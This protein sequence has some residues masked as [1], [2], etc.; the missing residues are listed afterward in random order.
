MAV[1]HILY[2]HTGS[3]ASLFHNVP[4]S[5]YGQLEED[6]HKIH[7]CDY[8]QEDFRNWFL[9]MVKEI[10]SHIQATNKEQDMRALQALQHWLTHNCFEKACSYRMEEGEQLLH[11]LSFS[12]HAWDHAQELYLVL[13]PQ[14]KECYLG[15]TLANGYHVQE[16]VASISAQDTTVTIDILQAVMKQLLTTSYK[17]DCFDV[18]CRKETYHQVLPYII[19]YVIQAPVFRI[20]NQSIR[21]RILT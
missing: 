4:I 14:G 21:P 13:H 18:L 11:V 9:Q 7:L 2:Q 17:A 8:M 1:F 16:S 6:V 10:V 20:H 12:N 5:F 3:L 19:L 15:Y